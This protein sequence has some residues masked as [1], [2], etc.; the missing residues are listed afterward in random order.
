M[1]VTHTECLRMQESGWYH[2]TYIRPF[3]EG[4]FFSLQEKGR[5]Q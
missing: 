2:G 4:R 5:T 3:L 1:H